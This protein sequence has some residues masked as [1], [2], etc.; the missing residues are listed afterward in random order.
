VKPKPAEAGM[1]CGASERHARVRHD[2]MNKG[3][4]STPRRRRRAAAR[5][6]P[7]PCANAPGAA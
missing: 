6:R 3:A 1:M 5:P 4:I 7:S 2:C